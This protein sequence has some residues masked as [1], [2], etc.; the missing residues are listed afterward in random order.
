MAKGG[1][2]NASVVNWMRRASFSMLWSRMHCI[3][4]ARRAISSFS[5][6]FS[7]VNSGV[8]DVV[9]CRGVKVGPVVQRYGDRGCGSGT[10]ERGV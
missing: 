6:K 8:V 7:L 3:S 10:R 4:E 9:V 1:G 2:A 5:R